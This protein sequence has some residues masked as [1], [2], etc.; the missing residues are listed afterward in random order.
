MSKENDRGQLGL[1][2]WTPR[3]MDDQ[4]TAFAPSTIR[5]EDAA[6]KGD[7]IIDW[8]SIRC[9]TPLKPEEFATLRDID[10][11]VCMAQENMAD[12]DGK[13]ESL[14]SGVAVTGLMEALLRAGATQ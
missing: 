9:I 10:V 6:T 14:P 7:P 2:A 3:Y 13:A 1:Q 4:T 11:A 5:H 12:N 8:E